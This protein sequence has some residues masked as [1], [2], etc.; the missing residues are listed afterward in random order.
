MT[1]IGQIKPVVRIGYHLIDTE[2]ETLEAWMG[3]FSE[4]FFSAGMAW[5]CREN[6][7]LMPLAEKMVVISRY[8]LVCEELGDIW[9]DW[10][11]DIG[12]KILYGRSW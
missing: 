4:T 2:P 12:P 6:W 11:W 1:T 10:P 3:L 5:V 7:K 8:L 9:Y